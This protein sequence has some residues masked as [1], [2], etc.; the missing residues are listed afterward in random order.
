MSDDKIT[1]KIKRE[2]Q[3][4]TFAELRHANTVLLDNAREQRNGCSYEFMTVI[5]LAAFKLEAYLNHVGEL[6]FPYW[7]EMESLSISC[8][9][10]TSPSPRHRG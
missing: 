6:L 7:D 4:N 2:R 5:L 8:L 10:Y 1:A 9:L 3:V